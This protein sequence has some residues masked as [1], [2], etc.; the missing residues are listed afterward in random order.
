M[1]KTKQLKWGIAFEK[2]YLFEEN[3]KAAIHI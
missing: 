2:V 1:L 3:N